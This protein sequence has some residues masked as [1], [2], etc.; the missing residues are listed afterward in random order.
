MEYL[1]GNEIN[2]EV[3][4]DHGGRIT[5]LEWNGIEFTLPYSSPLKGGC[6]VMG[7]W[8]GRVRDGRL[9]TAAGKYVDLPTHIDPP[10]AI[11]G[12]G[13]DS[14]W[15]LL[16]N[17]GRNR[18]SMKL[19]LPAPYKG[20]MLEQKIELL[21]NALR[22]SME[23]FPGE[24]E[25]PAWLGFHPWF[26]RTLKQNGVE[27]GD[28]VEINFTAQKILE[29]GIDHL[30]TGKLLDF[31][32]DIKNKVLDDAFKGMVGIPSIVWPGIARIEIESDVD[33]WVIYNGDE[34]GV[35]LEPMTA[36][37]DAAN[38]DLFDINGKIS[39]SIEALFVF[40]SDYEI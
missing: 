14:S 30:P 7:P 35:C 6:Y 24:V 26:A 32:P 9:K 40:N 23:Y 5:S 38:L 18:I 15:Q 31:S 27:L 19:D 29:R 3:D 12:Y 28:E 33:W 8:A 21:D 16:R 10:N 1:V 39:E 11:H 34:E 36:P 25:L 13:F 20:G 4:L 22:W 17:D 37:P 2:L